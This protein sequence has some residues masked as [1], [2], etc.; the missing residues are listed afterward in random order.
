MRLAVQV[1]KGT[2]ENQQRSL[3]SSSILN[4]IKKVN[5]YVGKTFP[6]IKTAA[7]TF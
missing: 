7:N 2:F 3:V 6:I 1:F 5:I 4:L